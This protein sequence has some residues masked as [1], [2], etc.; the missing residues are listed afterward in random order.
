MIPPV[1]S[2]HVAKGEPMSPVRRNAF[3]FVTASFLIPLLATAI[4]LAAEP[5]GK[6]APYETVRERGRVV[7]AAEAMERL[8][9]VTSG[10][11]ASQRV[12]AL[13][14]RDGRLLPLVEDVRG[15][16]F[17]N[18]ERLRKMEIELEARRRRGSPFLQVIRT[19]EI[20]EGRKFE[21]DYWCEICS[22]ALYE[23][24]PCDCCQGP[25]ELRR[26]EVK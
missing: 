4:S 14:T 10:E 23:L 16:A 26:R 13:E 25:L 8:H 12:L 21:L 7:W 24:K 17:R 18:D 20:K 2:P 15:R 9:G 5:D 1:G 22:I 19:Y 3:Y 6:P 11:E